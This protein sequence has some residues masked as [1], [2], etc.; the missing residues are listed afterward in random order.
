[1]LSPIQVLCSDITTLSLEPEPFASYT[2]GVCSILF[3]PKGHI[4]V[5]QLRHMTPLWDERVF[6]C[7][8]V[9]GHSDMR[10]CFINCVCEGFE[11]GVISHEAAAALSVINTLNITL[12]LSVCHI[13]FV[14]FYFCPYLLFLSQS[15]CFSVECVYVC[16]CVCVSVRDWFL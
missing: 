15:G 12:S 3:Y 7:A 2:E 10:V 16:V 5:T 6:V 8:P 1:M 9:C 14:R 13:L 4:Y 11:S